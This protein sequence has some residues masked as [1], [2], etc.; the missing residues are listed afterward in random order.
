[1]AER[2]ISIRLDDEAGR[3]WDSCSL[4]HGLPLSVLLEAMGRALADGTMTC[5]P[6][7]IE[8]AHRL[9]FERRSR[10]KR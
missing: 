10:R 1:M 7:V 5:P 2:R 9:E 3:G 4:R 6:E 8:L